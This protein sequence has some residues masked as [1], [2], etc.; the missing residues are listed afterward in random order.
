MSQSHNFFLDH[1]F[2]DTEQSEIVTFLTEIGLYFVLRLNGLSYSYTS[3]GSSLSLIQWRFSNG[4]LI[5]EDAA[6]VYQISLVQ[7]DESGLLVEVVRGENKKVVLKKVCY[8]NVL[9][10]VTSGDLESYDDEL[11]LAMRPL[12][13]KIL[14]KIL[15]EDTIKQMVVPLLS[16]LF[17]ALLFFSL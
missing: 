4:K 17:A 11:N 9:A 6:G 1:L 10:G 16:L 15:K 5:I 2:H 14:E 8:L 12:Y 13:M 3:V 7:P